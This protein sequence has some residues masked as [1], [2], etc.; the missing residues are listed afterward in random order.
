MMLNTVANPGRCPAAILVVKNCLKFSAIPAGCRCRVSVTVMQT[1][2]IPPRL[3]TC[4]IQWISIERRKGS[5]DIRRRHQHGV[6]RH[7]P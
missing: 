6:A 1:E 2:T 5:F 7:L 4:E 3:R